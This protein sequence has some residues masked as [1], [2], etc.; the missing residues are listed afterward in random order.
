[1]WGLA[2]SCDFKGAPGYDIL[3]ELRL[4]ARE[5]AK[6]SLR[7][8]RRLELDRKEA[9]ELLGAGTP[10]GLED[11]LKAAIAQLKED[12]SAIRRLTSPRYLRPTLALM[13]LVGYIEEKTGTPHYRDVSLLLEAAH[14]AFGN[15]SKESI[16]EEAIRKAVERFKR[17]N[18]SL[19]GPNRK[20]QV[21]GLLVRLGIGAILLT[22]IVQLLTQP[23]TKASGSKPGSRPDV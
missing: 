15:E 23:D 18:P 8:A 22:A 17:S 1:M 4:H 9:V 3:Q 16:G 21:T 20:F 14:A 19:V 11:G 2:L 7:M 5:S 6:R 13:L 10:A 12:A